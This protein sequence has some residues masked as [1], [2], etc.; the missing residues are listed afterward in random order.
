MRGII[1]RKSTYE[2]GKREIDLRIIKKELIDSTRK[3]FAFN[4]SLMR[5]T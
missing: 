1:G 5:T 3:Q 4:V 2:T